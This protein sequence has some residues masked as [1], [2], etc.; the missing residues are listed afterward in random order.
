[1][2][3]PPPRPELAHR[4]GH[5]APYATK[6][7]WDIDRPQPAFAALAERGELRGRVLDIGCGTGEHALMAA[8]LGHQAVGIDQSARAVE[9]AAIKARERG[10]DA[11]FLQHDALH[12]TDLGETFDTVLD[13]GL[14]HTFDPETRPAYAAS[15]ASVLRSGG[16]YVLLGFSDRQPGDWGPHRLSRKDI[17]TTFADGWRIDS[18]TDS[19]LEILMTPS[20]VQAWLGV[21][22]RL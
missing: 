20:T 16:R 6:E 10:L 21:L 9:L 17:E 19:T 7:P 3:T 22:T 5:D 4:D 11:R 18:L 8:G 13:C 12:L 1:M 14:F 15:L 2:S